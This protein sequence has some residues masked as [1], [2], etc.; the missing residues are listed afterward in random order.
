MVTPATVLLVDDHEGNLSGLRACLQKDYSG[1][2]TTSGN[3]AIRIA[4]DTPPDAVL[5]D[6][7][8]PEISGPRRLRRAQT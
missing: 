1:V 5:L 7:V 3:E 4:R 2:A 6:V 8:M